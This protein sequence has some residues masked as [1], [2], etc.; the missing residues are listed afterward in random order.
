MG[1]TGK[2]IFNHVSG[3]ISTHIYISSCIFIVI[4]LSLNYN[5]RRWKKKNVSIYHEFSRGR[6]VSIFT[7]KGIEWNI[8]KNIVKN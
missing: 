1:K 4:I 7:T 2:L 6:C 8:G 5:N 3:C